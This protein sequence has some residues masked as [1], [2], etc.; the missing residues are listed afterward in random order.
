[1]A[2]FNFC[3]DQ[4]FKA[5]KITKAMAE[6]IKSADDP[7]AAINRLVGDISRQKRETA[8]QSIRLA[9]AFTKMDSHE[10][11]LYDGL[12]SLLTKD[13]TG[14][15]GYGNVEYRARFNQGKYHSAFAD[16]LSRFRTRRLGFSQDTEGLNKLVK[17][18]YGESVDDPEIMKLA[19]SWTELTERI[20]KDFNRVGGSISKNERWLMPQNHDMRAIAK[21]GKEKWKE[22][23]LPKLDRSQMLDDTGNVLNDDQLSEALD[24]VF[25]TITTGG[26]NKVKDFSIPRLGTKLSRKGSQQRFLFFKDADSWLE[27]QRD[28]GRGDIFTTL[29]DWIDTKS[30]D[31]ALM[32]V[33]GVNPENTFNALRGQIEKTGDITEIQKAFSKAVF[34][35]VSGKTNQGELTSVA[36]FMQS[37]RNLLTA[38]TLGKAFL[39]AFSDIGFQAMT[40]NYNNIPA[41]KVLSRQLSLMNPAKEAD[42][43]AAVKMGL[44]AEA[45]LGRAHGSNRYADVYGTGVT[46]KAAEGVMRATLLSPWTDAGRKAFG[47]EFSSMLADNFGKSF[48]ELDD[49]VRR[50][51][52]TYGIDSSDWDKFRKSKTLDHDGAKFADLTQEG[53]DKF[54]QMILTEMDFAVPTPDAR[55]RAI[56]TGGSG[57]AT[58]GGQALRSVMMLKSFPITI[59]T[60]HF[61]RAAYQAT[62]LEKAA[63]AGTLLATTSVL[64]GI[65]L[66]AKDIAAGREPRPA[67][68]KFLAAAFAQGGGLGIFGDFLFS[69]VNRFGGGISQT[70]TGPT[71]ELFDTTVNTTVKLTFGNVR[72][73]VLGEETNVLGE[74]AQYLQRYTPD[75]WQTQLLS[76]AVFNQIR[77]MSDPDAERKFNRMVRKRE[78]EY[79]QGYWW[80]PGEV[81]PEALR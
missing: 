53:G 61:Y 11:G 28:F 21:I 67:D 36:D 69:D 5:G 54:S 16:A 58:V 19:K 78:K 17:A 55:V 46:A 63:Y 74:T 37:T 50:S 76:D 49:A 33:L 44:I 13:P 75:I 3:I 56:T 66:Q 59:A 47:M 72:E 79:D 6:T 24:F 77:L 43:V 4:A 14:K 73:A 41:F 80:R 45:W 48:D 27:Y 60:T 10:L 57:R 64:G 18:I 68:E 70:I 30:Q 34:N 25:D 15:A 35:V 7:E 52:D 65:A 31:I 9:D 42:R 51:F 81:L 71:G 8:I 39:S 1:V 38:S 12:M 20:R 2:D 23:I 29:T 40:A 32:E 26:M 62:G 22:S